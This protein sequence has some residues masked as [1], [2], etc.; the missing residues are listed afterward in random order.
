[1]RRLK[2]ILTLTA[3]L[4]LALVGCSRDSG[5]IAPSGNNDA[6]PNPL[7]GWQ[8]PETATLTSATLKVYVVESSYQTVNLYRLTRDWDEAT[9][10]WENFA[11]DDGGAY[12]TTVL[13]D[14][15]ANFGAGY[16][17]LD[18][19]A[20]VLAWMSGEVDNFGF[21]LRQPLEFS[22]RTEMLSRERETNRPVLELVYT[23]NGQTT[24]A[25]I[26]PLADAQINEAEPTTAFGFYDK[27]YA[28]WRE[29][30]EKVSLIRFDFDI[31]EPA[32][33]A[34]GDLVWFDTN[35][36]GVQDENEAGVPGVTVYLTNCEGDTL[37]SMLTDENG[38]Y[39]FSG[40]E[41]GDYA[42][43]FALPADFVFSPMDQ[44]DDALDS[45]ADPNTG[46]TICT[47]LVAGETD[48]TWDAGIYMPEIEEGC[49]LTI[50]YWKTHAGFGP[51]D[52]EVTPLLGSGIWLGTA[53]GAKSLAVTNR[54]I[55]RDV[56]EQNE[57][58]SPSNGITKLYAQLLGAKLNIANGASD[59]D[60]AA[61]IAAA[62][63]FLATRD[64]RAWSGLNAANRALVNGWQATLDDYNNGLI[65]PGHCDENDGCGGHYGG[66][67]HGGGHGGGGCG[68]GNNGGGHGGGG[69]G[70]GHGGGGN[71]GGHGGGCGH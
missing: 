50:G 45:D 52:D 34:I 8:L 36:N 62:D 15:T 51:Q 21:L 44:G 1:M 67:H 19:T 33:A 4:A 28:G 31:T 66:G 60:V 11:V 43:G 49:T 63:A 17:S 46:A 54:T 22:P 61:V 32:P 24:T 3:M 29:A 30:G 26:E 18:V 47:T 37:A 55:A 10:T 56:L 39:L 48:L 42:I 16:T 5:P 71:G 65:G 41:A 70:G 20:P 2:L 6:S 25:L 27:L 58:G 13:G 64:W 57:Y 53:G 40:L 35:A 9:V 69:N 12:D 38:R 23:L 59:A 68:G 14:F 7:F